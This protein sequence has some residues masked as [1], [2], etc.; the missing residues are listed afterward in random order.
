[1]NIETAAPEKA[2]AVSERQGSGWDI[3]N[4]PRNYAALIIFQL[5]SAA[6]S[7]GAVWLITRPQH[8]G[9]KGYGAIVAVIIASQVAQVFVNWTSIAVVRFGVDEFVE[10]ARIARTF[11]T[12]FAI[13]F[14]NL[15]LIL[16]LAPLWFPPLAD[17]L[18]LTQDAF[19]LVVVHFA[20]TALW[21]QIQMSLQGAK[22]LRVQGFLQMFERLVILAGI[23][24]LVAL[25]Q[26]EFYWA[27]VCYIVAPAAMALAGTVMLREFIFARFA[28]DRAI[29]KKILV[30]S[31]P[32]LPF[33]LVGYFSGSY[34]DGIFVTKFL[35]Q[36][37]LGVYSV[38]TQV[39]GLAMQ[40]PT[41]ANTI[42]LPLFV[43]LRAESGD[44]RTFNYFRNILPAITLFWG[45]A[46]VGL[47]FFGYLLV[48]LVFGVPFGP[49]SL[50]LWILLSS[51]VVSIPIAIGYSALANST[52]TTYV[53]MIAAFVSAAVNIGANFALIP[54]YG[55][56]GCA[57]A[58]LIAYFA[59]TTVFALLL[60]KTAKMPVSWTLLA[61]VPT[62]TGA[63][64]ISLYDSPLFALA[65]CLA[66][67]CFVG[68]FQRRSLIEM[69]SF[70]SNFRRPAHEPR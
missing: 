6:F 21:M 61:F 26:L 52:S 44:Q 63:V 8:L 47:A 70:I 4:A 17:W 3:S 66:V 48:P 62:V 58:T 31:L 2:A 57:W 60:K 19:W 50:P 12:R 28:F 24:G 14:I 42:L 36:S 56:A 37:D 59:S 11:W 16:V 18:K 39:N 15:V 55:M 9:E 27:V 1:M 34:I 7:F 54:K 5:A 23:V 32:L 41:L 43:T 69:Y 33:T 22:M 25:S 13:L 40:I 64:I 46:C 10:T 68:F 38:A 35:S 67:S 20:V 30:Y 49:A 53:P 45:L 51:S 29:V 65:A